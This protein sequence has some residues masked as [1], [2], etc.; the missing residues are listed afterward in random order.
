MD[1]III[2]YCTGVYST[3]NVLTDIDETIYNDDEA[4]N[5]EFKIRLFDESTIGNKE[6][7]ISYENDIKLEKWLKSNLLLK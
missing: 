7:V 2:S 5:K 1:K 6:E 4:V 3:A